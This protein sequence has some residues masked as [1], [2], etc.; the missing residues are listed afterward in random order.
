MAS[1]RKREWKTPQKEKREAWVVDYVDQEGKRRIKT[2]TRR[3]DADAW[4]TMTLTQIG[5]GVHTPESTSVT[6]MEAGHRW[7][8]HCELGG[9]SSEPLERSTIQQ[10]RQHIDLH[11]KPFFANRK[12]AQLNTPEVDTFV[13][14]M[15]ENGRSRK[16]AQ[17]VLTSLKTLLS[18]AQRKALVAQNVALPVKV[19][20]SKRHQT[21]IEIPTKEH[22][23]PS[24]RRTASRTSWEIR[25][26]FF[27][28]DFSPDS[29]G[30]ISRSSRRAFA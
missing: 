9:D 30:K 20:M 26:V 24:R 17:K 8:R 15:L 28:V 18:Y 12:L 2:F 23:R 19:G 14:W 5:M 21:K 11:M 1:V 27:A 29:R 4:R 3:K 22:P 10:R 6:L 13:T 16:M 25:R 7:L